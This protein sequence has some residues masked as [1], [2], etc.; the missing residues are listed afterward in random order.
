MAYRHIVI[1]NPAKLSTSHE[2][3]IIK[4]EDSIKIPLEDIVTITLED[5]AITITNA[6]LSK[7][8]EY[9]VELII[10]DRKRM[11]SGI[12]Q[13]FHRHSRQQAVLEM[14]LSFS[15]P[16]K[17]RIWQKIVVRKLE[18]QARC[19]ELVHMGDEAQK[20]Y[21]ISR[22]VE[23]G[24]RTNREAY[25]AKLYFE[26]LFGKGFQR[27]EDN[28]YNI[29]MNYGYSL[30]RSLVARALIRYGFTPSI[31]IFHDSQTNAFN[32]ADDFMEVLRPFVDAIIASN[33]TKESE[34]NSDLRKLLFQVLDIGAVWNEET[35]SVT[36]GVDNM[37]KS[38]V[39]ASRQQEA[40]MLILP[41]LTNLNRHRYE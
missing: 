3:L 32:L 35:L 9:H 10:C 11:P 5:P 2:Q 36:H 21:A 34:W 8:T 12:V 28:V 33:I 31:G 26:L 24:D 1:R 17:K 6:L 15:K 13:P 27:R 37:I 20:L 29:A 16:F 18:N 38:F 25:G 19:L 7:C 39:S 40:N 4:Q 23:S 41:E 30:I 14:Q 22:S